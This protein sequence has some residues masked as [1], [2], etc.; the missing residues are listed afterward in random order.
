MRRRLVE[1]VERLNQVADAL[2]NARQPWEEISEQ[3]DRSAGELQEK[4]LDYY[5]VQQLNGGGV[6]AQFRDPPA[7]VDALKETVRQ[8]LEDSLK[9][10]LTTIVVAFQTFSPYIRL[11]AEGVGAMVGALHAKVDSITGEDGMSG[12]VD[13]IEEAANLLRN[14]DLSLVT[15]PLDDLYGRIETAV[16]ALNPEPLRAILETARDAVGDLLSLSTLIDQD[17][18]DALDETYDNI[19]KS[20]EGLAPSEIVSS[21]LDPEYEELLAD[22][23]PV[24]DLPARLRELLDTTGRT[25]GDDAVA[26]LARVEVA[27]DNMLRAIPLAT[28]GQSAQAS[29]SVS[30]G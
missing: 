7:N 12:T 1:A 3:L 20:I 4:L 30:V 13:A 2:D 21:T 6:F 29:A 19:V 18:I 26:E 14:I 9:E 23:L 22:F 11:L 17:T 28:G 10:P 27:F 5:K 24:L 16:G 25:I 8:A 15:G